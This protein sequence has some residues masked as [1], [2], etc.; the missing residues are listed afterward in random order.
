MVIRQAES[1][2]M[3]FEHFPRNSKGVQLDPQELL[4]HT[5]GRIDFDR[6]EGLAGTSLLHAAQYDLETLCEIFKFS[7]LLELTEIAS[8]HPLDGKLVI[9]AF[10]EASTRTRLS[11]EAAVLRLDGKLLSVPDARVTGVAKG[12]ALADIG[13]M[14]N[15][16]GDLVVMRH[17]ETE[18]VEE[19]QRNLSL[20]LINAGNGTGEHPTQAMIDW[21]TLVKWRPEIVDPHCPGDRRIRLGVIGTPAKMRAVKSFLRMAASFRA[22]IREVVVISEADDP[23]GKDVQRS[24][25][26][27]EIPFSVSRDVG[28]VLPELDV[29]YRNSIALLKGSYEQLDRHERLDLDSPLKP[30]A[31]ILHPFARGSELSSELDATR[32][33]LYFAQAASAVFLRQA[34]L[35]CIL[36]RIG[37]VPPSIRFLAG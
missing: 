18:A 34:L 7:A 1:D 2:R 4:T 25:E 22:G 19:L 5:G 23:L 35:V 29:V 14:F 28:E 26:G 24:L 12:E 21:Y 31:V 17:P 3:G 20:P 32:H 8:H 15:T 33:N 9:T 10:F 30:E 16:Y 37:A 6:L 11:F 27:A 36:N 13:E